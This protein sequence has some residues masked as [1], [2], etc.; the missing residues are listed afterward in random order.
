MTRN[1]PLKKVLLA[2]IAVAAV[3]LSGT[4]A[5]ASNHT[6][7]FTK[8]YTS[9]TQLANDLD[10]GKMALVKNVDTLTFINNLLKGWNTQLVVKKVLDVNG[11]TFQ[12]PTFTS[13][14]TARPYFSDILR[15][16]CADEQLTWNNGDLLLDRVN[17]TTG[18]ITSD[19][20][21]ENKPGEISACLDP[22]TF[23]E[24][25]GSDGQYETLPWFSL[26]C[27]NKYTIKKVTA[28]PPAI[29]YTPPGPIS[30]GYYTVG[31]NP[32]PNP[33]DAPV[34][35]TGT[36][37]INGSNNNITINNT[38]TTTNRSPTVVKDRRNGEMW[39]MIGAMVVGQ[40]LTTG[41]QLW[42][43]D[44]QYKMSQAQMSNYQQIPGYY[45]Q[46]PPYIPPYI[47]PVTPPVTPTYYPP[48]EGNTGPAIYP[49]IQ[50]NT[51][52]TVGYNPI[53]GNAFGVNPNFNSIEGKVW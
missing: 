32:I 41:I 42:A 37:T 14:A 3:M 1:S 25:D 20:L 29:V 48:I 50:G 4:K 23:N 27:G 28:Q 44:R 35:N 8:A 2:I 52:N 26:L 21:R 24:V 9:T 18:A 36:P 5:F 51:G 33:Y 53:Q 47:P 15:N 34:N 13:I 43:M 6:A 17:K 7:F 31:Y 39:V 22:N 30:P 12:L 40:V 11:H 46:Q 10:K 38:S 16:H 49:P 45:Y 19:W